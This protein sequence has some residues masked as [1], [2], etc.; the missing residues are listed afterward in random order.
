M[1]RTFRRAKAAAVRQLPHEDVAFSFDKEERLFEPVSV[2]CFR[3]I[4]DIAC[5]LSGAPLLVFCPF[6]R[7]SLPQ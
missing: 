4:E 2:V 6:G 3:P 5:S 1:A 7:L